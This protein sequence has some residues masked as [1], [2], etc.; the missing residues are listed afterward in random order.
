MNGAV[1][2]NKSAAVVDSERFSLLS[3]ETEVDLVQLLALVGRNGSALSVASGVGSNTSVVSSVPG[4]DVA[5]E[6]TIGRSVVVRIDASVRVAAATGNSRFGRSTSVSEI[7]LRADSGRVAGVQG[8]LLVDTHDSGVESDGRALSV[9]ASVS[10]ISNSSIVQPQ[11]VVASDDRF[12]VVGGSWW[13]NSGSLNVTVIGV[14]ATAS[15]DGTILVDGVTGSVNSKLL[16]DVGRNALI[17]GHVVFGNSRCERSATSVT[18]DCCT[19][20]DSSR[21]VRIGGD[22]SG[23]ADHLLRFGNN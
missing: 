5:A 23:I 9:A 14:G 8:S 20:H 2:W 7:K 22:N 17:E 21:V 15:S 18:F 4:S 1:R 16:A 12:G 19:S 10:A 11:T 13:I 6:D 3:I